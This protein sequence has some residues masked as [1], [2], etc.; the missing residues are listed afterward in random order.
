MQRLK[1]KVVVV[2]GASI[3]LGQGIALVLGE[4]GA[5][6]YVTGRSVRGEQR[7]DFSGANIEDTAAQ[8][9]ARGGV[10]IPFRCDHSVD[11][12]VKALFEHVK[13]EHGR[14]DILVNNAWGGYYTIDSWESW[15]APFWEQ[16]LSRWDKIFA[17]GLR[18]HMVSSYC[19]VPL[20]LPQR[21]GLIINT[22]TDMSGEYP[23]GNAPLSYYLRGRAVSRMT[24]GMAQ[25]LQEH[26]IAVVALAPD[27]LRTAYLLRE[28]GTDDMNAHEI[29]DL[30]GSEST[31]Y[32]GRAVVALATDPNVM[33]KTGQLLKT[34]KLGR[35]YGFTDVD[36]RQPPVWQPG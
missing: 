20:M 35:E 13:R 25:E 19:A 33:E 2:T 23:L 32:A 14:I 5:T 22:T 16:P 28:H 21:Q 3:N 30:D 27:W 24:Y 26:N 15:M 17:V 7:T 11:E 1:G 10:G 36:G 9:S 31:R 8:I 18:S 12:Q 29:P 6:V 4:E 34:R